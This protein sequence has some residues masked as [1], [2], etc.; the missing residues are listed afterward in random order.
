M[1]KSTGTLTVLIQPSIINTRQIKANIFGHPCHWPSGVLD[2]STRMLTSLTLV[3]RLAHFYYLSVAV[4]LRILCSLLDKEI[5]STSTLYQN[6]SPS[7]PSQL[8]EFALHSS[9]RVPVFWP[10]CPSRSSTHGSAPL[11]SL[12][13]VAN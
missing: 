12:R 4:K 8:C 2:P 9:V 1:I 5:P 10:P 11:G 3:V 6:V 7:I 13:E